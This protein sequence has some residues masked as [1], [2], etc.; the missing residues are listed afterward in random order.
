MS[1]KRDYY[2]VL[3][4]QRTADEREIKSAY[5]KLA[6]KYHPDRNPN[7]PEA[8]KV[9][10]ECAEAYEVLSDSQKRVLYDRGGHEGLKSGGFSGFQGDIGDI[11]SSFGDIFA[12]FFGGSA[13]GGSGG[14]RR[15]MVGA[16]QGINLQIELKEAVTGA[17]RT[18]E[19][20]RF[21]CCNDCGGTGADGG[22]LISCQVCG[23]RGQVVQGRGGFMIATTCRAC[24]GAGQ[25]PRRACST[26][27]GEGQ[28]E[29]QRPLSIRVPPGV[30]S[31]TRMRVQGRGHG[32]A[33][34]GP[35][36][37]LYVR[38]LVEDHPSY[39]RNGPDLHCELAIDFP[40]ACLGGNAE[41]PQI[42]EGSW[43]VDIPAGT[44]PGDVIRISGGGMP[45][46]DSRQ[47]GDL[48]V[49]LTVD[50]PRHLS[51]DQRKTIEALQPTLAIE[52]TISSG[53]NERRETKSRKRKGG[54][55]FDRIR[56]ALEGD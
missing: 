11:F 55:F 23:G 44:Q 24:G 10:R 9:F 21:V 40:T 39:V 5:R 14:G 51:D 31:G 47:P 20:A 46:M 38:I 35:P 41:V 8:E 7:D 6:L 18:V 28:I 25:T 26:C 22:E 12:E 42:V 56:D 19:V 33:N 45:R 37:D 4:V 27:G 52:P 1:G 50:V 49:H 3:G 2:E 53:Q 29:E 36:G 48:L 43:P 30:D 54:G 17:T 34:G 15:P 16:D 32:G 13:F